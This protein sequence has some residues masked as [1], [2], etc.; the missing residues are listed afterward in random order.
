M[1]REEIIQITGLSSNDLDALFLLNRLMQA[2]NP[3]PDL[4]LAGRE[5]EM[6]VAFLEKAI[7]NMELNGKIMELRK[8]TEH[9]TGISFAVIR[10]LRNLTFKSRYWH[11]THFDDHDKITLAKLGALADL[12]SLTHDLAVF[13]SSGITM[14]SARLSQLYQDAQWASQSGFSK[15]LDLSSSTTVFEIKVTKSGAPMFFNAK[16]QKDQ[17]ILS[18]FLYSEEYRIKLDKLIGH[19]ETKKFLKKHLGDD[20]LQQLEH[21]FGLI[22]REIHDAQ[23]IGP[24]HQGIVHQD[25]SAQELF[26]AED[27]SPVTLICSPFVG[28]CTMAAIKELNVQMVQELK[29]KGVKDIP[30]PLLQLPVAEEVAALSP[31]CFIDTLDKCNALER[32]P[33]SA[34]KGRLSSDKGEG[35]EERPS[36][37][38]K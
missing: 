19:D 30:S 16:Q 18:E 4:E 24:I 22:Q 3:R 13:E 15:N 35:D 8:L 21:K 28:M 25:A 32:I 6:V 12:A 31:S 5:K 9:D 29:S 11:Q 33:K 26:Q 10:T 36:N 14:E 37:Q 23:L 7:G 34:M 2:D 1:T 17:F 27:K 20:W 38:P